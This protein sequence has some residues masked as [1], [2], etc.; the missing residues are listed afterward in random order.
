[1]CVVEWEYF[2]ELSN[3]FWGDIE[4]GD[5][6]CGVDGLGNGVIKCCFIEVMLC[7]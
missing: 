5:F 6:F 7:V 3:V 4:I 2:E 1:M